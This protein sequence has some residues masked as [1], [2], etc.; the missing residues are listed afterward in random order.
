M[1]TATFANPTKSP[2]PTRKQLEGLYEIVDDRIVEKKNVGAEEIRFANRLAILLSSLR[3]IAKLGEFVVE[4]V[5][6]LRPQVNRHRRPDLAFVSYKKWPRAERIPDGLSWPVIPDLA[7]EIIS[8]TNSASEV[9]AKTRE[10]FTAGVSRVWA[11]YPE[12]REIELYESPTTIRI[13]GASDTLEDPA[14]WPGV[15]I[16]LSKIFVA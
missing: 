15:K 9:K 12:F 2:R 5:F 11:V 16:K 10:Y 7:I 1:S 8:K 6:D 3:G 4:V 13:L 14:L